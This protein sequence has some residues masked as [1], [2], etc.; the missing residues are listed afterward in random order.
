MEE[1]T[2]NEVTDSVNR[3][4]NIILNHD[5][6]SSLL[7]VSKILVS[8][9]EVPPLLPVK[10]AGMALDAVVSTLYP[11]DKHYQDMKNNPIIDMLSALRGEIDNVK[12]LSEQIFA[13][14]KRAYHTSRIE[15]IQ[16]KYENMLKN[17]NEEI[18]AEAFHLDWSSFEDTLADFNKTNIEEFFKSVYETQCHENLSALEESY[19]LFVTARLMY[20]F[21]LI[22]FYQKTT[23]EK[24]IQQRSVYIKSEINKLGEDLKKIDDTI[25]EVCEFFHA[26]NALKNLQPSVAPVV[27]AY[28][29]VFPEEDGPEEDLY[30]SH[31]KWTGPLTRD[32]GK[33]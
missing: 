12:K 4:V 27:A 16:I 17:P 1:R 3:S 14:I 31:W 33:L 8:I 19:N 11:E 18:W 28:L 20:F 24:I 29:P 22:K 9:G 32:P 2:Y 15:R 7:V 13:T 5:K 26:F 25:D 21:V 30:N 6:S 23:D 10:I